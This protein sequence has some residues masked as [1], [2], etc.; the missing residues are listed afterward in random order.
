M[1]TVQR[2]HGGEVLAV[3]DAR[4][5]GNA[6]LPQVGPIGGGGDDRAVDGGHLPVVGGQRGGH[7]HPA[8]DGN[9]EGDDLRG[10]ASHAARCSSARALAPTRRYDPPRSRPSGSAS[11]PAP[12]RPAPSADRR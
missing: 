5:V 6:R 1:Q 3:G 8:R 9:H 4:G 11:A 10:R 7:Q 12:P 2:Q